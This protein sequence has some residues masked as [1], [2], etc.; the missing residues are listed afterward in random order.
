MISKPLSFFETIKSLSGN[1]TDI[2]LPPFTVSSLLGTLPEG[3]GL[4]QLFLKLKKLLGREVKRLRETLK[5][6]DA[7]LSKLLGKACVVGGR[8]PE[9]TGALHQQMDRTTYL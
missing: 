3:L 9:A 1:T 5:S 6:P 2:E 7:S 4:N 8:G